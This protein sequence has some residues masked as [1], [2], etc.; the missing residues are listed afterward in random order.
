MYTSPHRITAY[1]DGNRWQFV[2]FCFEATV[3]GGQLGHSDEVTDFGYFAQSEIDSLDLMEN[4]VERVVD[5]FAR[6]TAAFVR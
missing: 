5:A 4:H 2:S 6:A 3:V 1:A